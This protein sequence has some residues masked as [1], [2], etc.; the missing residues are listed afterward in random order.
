MKRVLGIDPGSRITGYGVI[1]VSDNAQNTRCIASGCISLT[2]QEMPAR[3]RLLYEKICSVVQSYH[4]TELAIEQI[5]VHKNAHSALKLGQARVVSLSLIRIPGI[6]HGNAAI[7][8]STVA[9]INPRGGKQL[10]G[11]WRCAFR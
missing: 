5:F 10:S 6:G 7:L 3:L 8:N 1:E 2:Q 11:L 9:S 4:P